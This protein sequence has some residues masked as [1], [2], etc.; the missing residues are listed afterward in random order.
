MTEEGAY[1][2]QYDSE[3]VLR[4]FLEFSRFE[5]CL[6]RGGFLKKG[7]EEAVPDWEAFAK[8]LQGKLTDSPSDDFRQG[9]FVLTARPPKKQIVSLSGGL[10]WREST[11]GVKEAE[12][13]F[14][15]RLVR[16]VRNNLF[17]GGKFPYP[18]GPVQDPARDRELVWAALIVLRECR[19]LNP[20][21]DSLFQE[22]A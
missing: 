7:R 9:Y 14:L 15:L 10:G 19:R 22:A 5:Y 2:I 3:L 13:A 21:I 20:R 4:F 1:S 12:E 16:T 8:S 18:D 6:K 11:R 17:H